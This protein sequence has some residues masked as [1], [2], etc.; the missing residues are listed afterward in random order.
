MGW[1]V[2]CLELL[3]VRGWPNKEVAAM[4]KIT[5]QA[6]ANHKHQ[7]IAQLQRLAQS[8]GISDEY[9]AELSESS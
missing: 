1:P 2:K 8:A 9:V 3:L 7:T 5:E 4:L 6:V